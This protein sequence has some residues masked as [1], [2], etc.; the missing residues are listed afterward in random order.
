MPVFEE[1]V[2]AMR[3]SPFV[4]RQLMPRRGAEPLRP[5]RVEFGKPSVVFLQWKFGVAHFFDP[6]V[7][8]SRNAPDRYSCACLDRCFHCTQR[9]FLSGASR[10]EENVF[11]L[12]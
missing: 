7:T 11:A 1:A 3:V 8:Q 5:S 12:Q 10:N 2:I 9:C 6:Q 4:R